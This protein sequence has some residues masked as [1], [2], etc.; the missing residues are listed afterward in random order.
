MLQYCFVWFP[1]LSTGYGQHV[2]SA[3]RHLSKS[4]HLIAALL[5]ATDI[6]GAGC[7]A[8]CAENH[9]APWHLRAPGPAVAAKPSKQRSR[10]HPPAEVG[11][12]THSQC[13]TATK[14]LGANFHHQLTRAKDSRDRQQ[15]TANKRLTFGWPCHHRKACKRSRTIGC[16]NRCLRLASGIGMARDRT[17]ILGECVAQSAEARRAD[18]FL[19]F[20]FDVGEHRERVGAQCRR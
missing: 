18:A 16:A 11:G 7:G 3:D 14:P 1:V 10:R 2:G 17:P 5:A 4:H 12:A 13:R 19:E 9:W 8:C 15:P 6:R 20:G